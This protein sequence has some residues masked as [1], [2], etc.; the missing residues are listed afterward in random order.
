MLGVGV[1]GLPYAFGLMGWWLALVV[2][3]IAALLSVYSTLIIGTHPAHSQIIRYGLK[4][5]TT[6]SVVSL[7]RSRHLL[8]V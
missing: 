1:L 5:V 2:M 8:N 7:T 6:V 4:T 3:A